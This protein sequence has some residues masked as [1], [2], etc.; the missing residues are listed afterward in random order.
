M[1]RTRHP[2]RGKGLSWPVDY[3]ERE[4]QTKRRLKEYSILADMMLL[5]VLTLTSTVFQ[6]FTPEKHPVAAYLL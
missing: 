3:L 2:I 6:T 1:M 5:T 4:K